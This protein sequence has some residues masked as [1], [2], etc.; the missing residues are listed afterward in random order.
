MYFEDFILNGFYLRMALVLIGVVFTIKI[1]GIKNIFFLK[2]YVDRNFFSF[3]KLIYWSIAFLS[4]WYFEHLISTS[5]TLLLSSSF[6]KNYWFSFFIL[7]LLIAVVSY[8]FI[9]ML[10]GIS[11]AKATKNEIEKAQLGKDVTSLLSFASFL[12]PG[13]VVAKGAFWG[14]TKLFDV[15]ID[16][17]VKTNLSDKIKENINN[18]LKIVSI[19]LF[20][21]L[22]STYLIRGQIIF[23]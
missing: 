4:I 17:K 10:R 8:A 23:W 3:N 6:E 22:G 14:V 20:I 1:I 2:K 11:D 9:D 19:N 7:F 16:N 15:Y 5:S 18:M 13:G 21:V 12:I